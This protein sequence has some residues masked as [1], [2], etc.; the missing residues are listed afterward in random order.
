MGIKITPADKWFS[1][2]VR[3]R[4]NWTCEYAGTVFADAQMTCKTNGLHCSHFYGRGNWAVRFEPLNAF[5]HSYGSHSLLG[6]DSVKFKAWTE[7]QLGDNFDVLVELAN[8]ST[9][10]KEC[11]R[12]NKGRGKQNA[13]L[14]HYKSEFE[15]MREI[16]NDGEQG[17]IDFVGFI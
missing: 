7:L 15:R 3:E 5:S 6:G 16:R 8:S 17:R 9:R 4:N 12:A 11:K 10:G 13:L 14:S 2:C 1:L